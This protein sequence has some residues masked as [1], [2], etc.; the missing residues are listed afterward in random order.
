MNISAKQLSTI[1]YQ[2]AAKNRC[3]FTDRGQLET[4]R[5]LSGHFVSF[6]LPTW[7]DFIFAFVI[8]YD[9]LS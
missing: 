1:M 4:C 6:K 3:L 2:L 8:L 9:P 5:V 7:E